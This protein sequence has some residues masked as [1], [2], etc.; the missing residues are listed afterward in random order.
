M[1]RQSLCAA[2]LAA[3]LS[4]VGAWNGALANEP[5]PWEM[6]MQPSASPV[7]HLMGSFN[8]LLTVV[9]TLIV[10]FVAGLIAYCAVR[11]NAKANPV[12]SRTS[13][14]TVLEVAW[15]VVPVIIL[16]V[17]AVPSFKL[18]YAAER[19]PQADMTVK[20][21]GHQWYWDYEYPDHGGFTFSSYMIP[22]AD[23]KPGQRRL[24]EVDNR[25]VVPVNATVRVL[26]TAG[27]VIHSWAIPSFGVKKDGVPGRINETWFK[28]EREGVYYGQCS[29]I[30][31]T[32]HGYMPIVVEA[33]SKEAFD[34]WVAKAKTA[35]APDVAPAS[36]DVAQRPTE[37]LVE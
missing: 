27:D 2:G 23:L 16:I 37:T 33:V 12:P 22:E 13:H 21:T 1:K 19:I 30:C 25:V 4:M 11:F 7:K 28:A 9:I 3:V 36:R 31:G 24:L 20:V 6:G 15:T 10:I 8:D 29:E 26:V 5:R 32:N 14:H 18:L 35:Y 34:A 17:I